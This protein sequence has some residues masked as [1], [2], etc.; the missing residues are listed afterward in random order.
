MRNFVAATSEYNNAEYVIFGAPYDGTQC[1]RCDSRWTPRAIRDASWNLETYVRRFDVDICDTAIHDNGDLELPRDP[2][3]AER[4]VRASADGLVQ[5]N[6]FPVMLGGEHSVT[7]PIVSALIAAGVNPGVVS[8]DSHLD[9]HDEYEG[10]KYSHACTSWRLVE[11]LECPV[12]VIGARSGSAEEYRWAGE[13]LAVFTPGDV[14]EIGA[15]EVADLAVKELG[16]DVIYLS[17]DMDGVDAAFAPGVCTPEFFGLTPDD[18]GLL[19]T[20]LASRA[21]GL[22]VV[23]LAPH[24]DGGQTAMLA[25]TFI[26]EFICSRES[27]K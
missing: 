13:R 20:G 4:A 7:V 12:A 19:I 6:K 22:D 25:A 8:I 15:A 5:D 17:L 2:E 9:A 10:T 14:K 18:T 27:G 11:N 3:L 26:R 16:T 1:Y 21:V 23:E 24:Y